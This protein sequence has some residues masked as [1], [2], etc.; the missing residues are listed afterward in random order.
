[1]QV[2]IANPLPSNNG[3]IYIKKTEKAVAL[4]NN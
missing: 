3:K 2:N 1:M 4:K